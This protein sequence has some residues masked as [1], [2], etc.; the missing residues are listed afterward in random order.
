[1]A[2]KDVPYQDKLPFGKYKG[3]DIKSVIVKDPSYIKWLVSI[4]K[5]LLPKFL[6]L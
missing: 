4:G 1:M 6:K 5:L 3:Q 2:N